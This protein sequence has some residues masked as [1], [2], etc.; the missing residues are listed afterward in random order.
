MAGVPGG[1]AQAEARQCLLQDG[2][3][4]EC[5]AEAQAGGRD[6]AGSSGRMWRE[7]AH[8]RSGSAA[9]MAEP[10]PPSCPQELDSCSRSCREPVS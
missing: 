1:R 2:S 3:W 7:L 10:V 9:V 8:A 5:G 6:S 4:A